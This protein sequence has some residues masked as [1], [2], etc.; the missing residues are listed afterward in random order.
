[1]K[2]FG[3]IGFPL[4]HSFSESYFARK[5]QQE[6]ITDCV[7]RNFP[8]PEIASLPRLLKDHPELKGLNVTIPYKEKVLP[9]LTS[10]NDVVKSMNACNCIRIDGDQLAGFNTDTIGFE[11]SLKSHLKPHHKKALILGEG[12]AA[13]AVAYVFEQLGIEFLFVV[14]KALPG[15]RRILYQDLTD[16]TIATH[17]II[18]NS[19]PLGMYPNLDECPPINYS[20]ISAEH[21]LY[22]LIYNP[23]KTLFLRRGEERGATIKNGHEMLLIQA[24]ESWKIWNAGS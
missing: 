16:E 10:V 11:L 4:S 22:D 12:G 2:T 19:T 17:H 6:Q 18:V 23:E 13:K 21:Y 14:R 7:Y 1:M 3:L 20:H 9:Y 24:E 8:I 15:D 5:F